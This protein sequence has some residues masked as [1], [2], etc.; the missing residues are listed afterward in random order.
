MAAVAYEPNARST[1]VAVVNAQCYPPT[2]AWA[3]RPASLAVSAPLFCRS[4]SHATVWRTKP[5]IVSLR[6]QLQIAGFGQ[7][8]KCIVT[9]AFP[10]VSGKHLAFQSRAG[11]IRP[12]AVAVEC[13]QPSALRRPAD[14][15]KTMPIHLSRSH[16]VPQ[17][18]LRK[19]ERRVNTPPP[20]PSI[21]GTASGL[22]PPA[23]PHV[24][25]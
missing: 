21:E 10:Q 12:K 24:K 13:S 22:R 9:Q 11:T 18:V 2:S 15:A 19:Q 3:A 5:T 25:R 6:T 4:E 20:N 1:Q 17:V 23:A 7:A 8:A 16:P 14:K